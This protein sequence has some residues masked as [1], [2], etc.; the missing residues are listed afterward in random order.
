MGKAAAAHKPRS[1]PSAFIKVAANGIVTIMAKNPEIGQGIKTTLPMVIADELD[2][3]WKD[4]R[5]EQAD[6]DQ[7]KYG[8]QNA[9]GSTAIPQNWDPM[10]QVGAAARQMFVSAAAQTW[11]VPEAECT[12]ASGRVIHK[13]S[14]KSIGYGELAAKVATMTPPDPK[15]VKLKDPKDYKIIGQPIHGVD[16][17]AIVTGKPIYGIDLTLPGMLWAVYEKC[18]VF[19]GKVISANLDEIKAMPGVKHAFIVEGG[20]RSHRPDCPAS[21]SWPIAGGRR[22]PL[23]RS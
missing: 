14:N 9:G 22:K 4:V 6:L 23:A 20:H 2:V 21:R 18:P 1:L 11:G 13:A 7:A 17:A 10:R 16:N 15:T 3:D 12:T 5:V 19:G 8:G